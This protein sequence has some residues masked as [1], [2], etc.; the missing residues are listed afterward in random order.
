MQYSDSS[1]CTVGEAGD[2]VKVYDRL[3]P[4]VFV[5]VGV[6]LPQGVQV[7]PKASSSR[8]ACVLVRGLCCA[9]TLSPPPLDL[10]Q[11]TSAPGSTAENI[12]YMPSISLLLGAVPPRLRD[13]KS[14]SLLLLL[15]LLS[16]EAI[17][18]F[19]L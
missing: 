18:G 12:Y 13:G 3:L 6:A 10:E 14:D 1:E 5:P 7:Y 8:G 15:P 19:V 9:L 17:G 11:L 4:G 2:R 16:C